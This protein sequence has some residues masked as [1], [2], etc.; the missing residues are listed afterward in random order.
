PPSALPPTSLLCSPHPAPRAALPSFPTRRSSDLI[1]DR[2]AVLVGLPGRLAV[3]GER[4]YA[5]G[6]APV[7]GLLQPGVR[8][9]EAPAVEDEVRSEDHTSELQSLTNLVC[10]LLLEKKKPPTTTTRR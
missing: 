7:V 4:P 5:A 9:D 1:P 2:Q 10:R 3:Q 8:D 6:R